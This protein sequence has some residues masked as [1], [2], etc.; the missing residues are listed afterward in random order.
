MTPFSWIS[1]TFTT[2]SLSATR[3]FS[4]IA[5]QIPSG[6]F[7]PQPHTFPHLLPHGTQ[8]ADPVVQPEATSSLN[9]ILSLDPLFSKDSNSLPGLSQTMN[10]TDSFA[11]HH[12][13]PVL[14]HHYQNALLLWFN[15]NLFPSYWSL[16]QRTHFEVVLMHC[17]LMSQQSEALTIQT[18]QL[19][20]RMC[21]SP[22][23]HTPILIENIFPSFSQRPLSGETLLQSTWRPVAILPLALTSRHTWIDK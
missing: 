2:G 21:S 13:P 10:P 6:T 14:F 20:P 7:P 22:H 3:T 19:Q 23:C 17:P 12:I 15:L 18:F 16:F 8:R 1:F 11:C 9:T 5:I 4:Y